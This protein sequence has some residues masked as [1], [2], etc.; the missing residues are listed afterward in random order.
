MSA[1]DLVSVDG[2]RRELVAAGLEVFRS[3]GDE[4]ALAERPRE[5]LI[6]DSG[7][8]LRVGE[9]LEVRVAF[10]VQKVDF[11]NDDQERLFEHARRKAAPA[12]SEGF[13]EVTTSVTSVPDPGN[14]LR[15]LD[16]FY[17]VVYAKESAAVGDAIRLLKRALSFDK[18]S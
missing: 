11:P 9:P 12:R 16:T 4:I 8:V 1:P 13:V 7:V 10:Y 17:S 3:R 14:H 2:I 15:T 5:N 18:D 6:M